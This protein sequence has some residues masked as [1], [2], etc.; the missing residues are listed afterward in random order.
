MLTYTPG[1]AVKGGIVGDPVVE[2]S[3]N[4]FA[5]ESGRWVWALLLWRALVL[6][7]SSWGLAALVLGPS[8]WGL[9]PLALLVAAWWSDRRLFGRTAS[10][11]DS[12]PDV[13][14]SGGSYSEPEPESELSSE[15]SPLLSSV[16]LSIWYASSGVYTFL[17]IVADWLYV[18]WWQVVRWQVLW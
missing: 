17:D 13:L 9:P 12:D 14:P 4:G 6:G 16:R 7:L 8:S 15:S 10:C 1:W 11:S 18:L 2:G 5:K 3:H